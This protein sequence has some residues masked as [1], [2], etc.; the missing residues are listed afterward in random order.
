MHAMVLTA[1][2]APLRFEP[3]EDPVPGPGD[4][5]VRVSACGV[6]RT[7]LH[8][9]DGELPE[10]AYPII[11]GHEVVGRVDAL[12][13]GVTHLKIGERVGVPWLGYTCGE[14][15]YC[16]SG[17]ENLCDRP[18]IHRLYPRRRLCHASRRGRPLLLS[19]RRGRRR[20]RGC[21]SA[22]R[23]PDRLAF[24]GHGGGGKAS[25]HLR[26]RRG[27]AYHRAGGPLAGPLGLCVYARGRRRGAGAREIAGRRMGWRSE[28]GPPFRWTRPSS[29]RRSAPRSAGAASR[30]KGRAGGLRRHSH[31][32]YSLISLRYS[33]GGAAAVSVAN[34]TRS[35]GIEFFKVAAQAGIRTH[36]TVFPLR[37]ANEV[38]RSCAPG[39]ITG[40]AVLQP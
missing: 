24:A 11:P 12:G 35:D 39:R 28:D 21:T 34:L 31:V 36:T 14:C 6:C 4:V 20:R 7:D 17:Q 27:R 32:G 10:I 38:C 2:G 9:V 26:L 29:T 16:R 23:R 37:E 40:A 3:R 8:V 15:F 33:L 19:A 13:A 25:R 18:R 30:A 1:P 5:R 22:L